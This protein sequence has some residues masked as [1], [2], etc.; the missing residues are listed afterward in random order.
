MTERR[1]N[2]KLMSVRKLLDR[3]AELT[4]REQK[5]MQ[6]ASALKAFRPRSVGGVVL[7][8]GGRRE[9]IQTEADLSQPMR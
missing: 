3:M 5:L 9:A 1:P 4:A 6:R 7:A 2:T 8:V